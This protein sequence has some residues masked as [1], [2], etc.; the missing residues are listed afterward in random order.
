MDRRRWAWKF[1]KTRTGRRAAVG[2][3]DSGQQRS[4]TVPSGQPICSSS[5]VI[6]RDAAAGLYMACKESGGQGFKSPQLHHH[7]TAGHRTAPLFSGV[8]CRCRIARFVPPACHS[9]LAARSSPGSTRP[10]SAHTR[11][12][13]WRRPGWPC[14]PAPCRRRQAAEAGAADSRAVP[15][16]W[17]AGWWS[18]PASGLPTPRTTPGQR[19]DR[20][21]RPEPGPFRPGQPESRPRPSVPRSPMNPLTPQTRSRRGP[22]RPGTRI[23]IS[24]ERH[25]MGTLFDI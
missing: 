17:A 4:T 7:I 9:V 12:P 2:P 24:H 3:R 11:R 22:G 25:A 18:S 8:S 20:S 6:S 5:A 13:R 19:V 14:R 21:T 1:G 23:P 10:R 16:Y 15:W